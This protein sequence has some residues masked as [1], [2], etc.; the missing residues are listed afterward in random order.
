MVITIH[1]ASQLGG[2]RDLMEGLQLGTVDM[3]SCSL[4]VAASFV[5]ELNVMNLPFLFRASTQPGTAGAMTEET[6]S[7]GRVS[8]VR[9]GVAGP[10]EA[11][12]T[13][14]SHWC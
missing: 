3:M 2:E 7:L 13:P 6:G 10:A 11:S 5:P 4:G 1:P 14:A 12:K 8:P 9:S